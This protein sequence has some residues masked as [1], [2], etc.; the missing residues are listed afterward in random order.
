MKYTVTPLIEKQK[1][2]GVYLAGTLGAAWSEEELSLAREKIR[3]V[4]RNPVDALK[5]GTGRIRMS[6]KIGSDSVLK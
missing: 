5:S 4:V 2:R 1:K 3:W 6:K